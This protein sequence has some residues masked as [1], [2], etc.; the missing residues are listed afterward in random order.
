LVLEAGGPLLGV[1]AASRYEAEQQLLEPGDLLAMSTDEITEARRPGRGGAFFGHDGLVAAVR[2]LAG[3]ES[4]AA[5]GQEVARRARAFA[6]GGPQ[7][8]DVCL[9]LA[10]RR[11]YEQSPAT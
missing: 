10:R 2:D 9:L 6:G 7:N 8:D 3:S 11:V 4:L 5:I 1:E